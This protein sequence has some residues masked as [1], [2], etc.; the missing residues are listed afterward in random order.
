MDS[1]GPTMRVQ[2]TRGGLRC[3]DSDRMLDRIREEFMRQSCAKFPEF[4]EPALVRVLLRGIAGA[5]F[6]ERVHTTITPPG[7]DLCMRQNDTLGLLGFLM[8]DPRLFQFMERITGCSRIGH[9]RGNVCILG[10]G[11]HYQLSWHDDRADDRLAAMSINL[12]TDT[13]EGGALEMRDRR[14]GHVLSTTT[15]GV[16]DAVLIRLADH[17]QHRVTDVE[18]RVNRTTFVGWFKTGP[19]YDPPLKK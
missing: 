8:N 15:L 14:S 16:G 4:L 19:D 1:Q 18:G 5:E 12:S 7:T 13:F 2:L 11:Q 10:S 9:F 6:F 17:L 3:P